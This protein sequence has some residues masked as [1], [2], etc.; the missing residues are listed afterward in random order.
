MRGLRRHTRRELAHAALE[1]MT[2]VIK[3]LGEAVCL[4]PSGHP[5]VNAG[6]TFAMSRHSQLPAAGEVS[7]AVFGERLTELADHARRLGSAVQGQ[8]P[9]AVDL[10]A[11]A[12]ANLARL[13]AQLGSP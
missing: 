13:S 12:R 10:V 8:D 1:L 5:G 7:R 9:L 4:L 11:G 3:P 6:P 2:T